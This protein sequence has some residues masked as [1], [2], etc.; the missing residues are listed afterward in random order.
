MRA[1]VASM[2]GS[3]PRVA[4]APGRAGFRPATSSG[5]GHRGAAGAR[6]TSLATAATAAGASCRRRSPDRSGSSA[7]TSA[8]PGT[9]SSLGSPDSTPS[10][11]PVCTC[12]S[13]R[14]RGQWREKAQDYGPRRETATQAQRARGPTPWDAALG[15]GPWSL[16]RTEDATS[17]ARPLWTPLAYTRTLTTGQGSGAWPSPPGEGATRSASELSGT[18]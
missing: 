3:R 4:C 10:T 9:G 11:G 1:S 6:V 14:L 8:C 7:G 18:Y 16:A 5:G 12:R 17:P 15:A 13:E 2:R